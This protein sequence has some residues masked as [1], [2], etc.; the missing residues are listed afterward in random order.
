LGLKTQAA[1]MHAM[2]DRPSDPSSATTAAA[3]AAAAVDGSNNGADGDTAGAAAAG[4]GEGEGGGVLHLTVMERK[5]LRHRATVV[6]RAADALALRLQAV[7]DEIKSA[8]LDISQVRL[9]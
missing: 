7:Q 5:A 6:Q 9:V 4:V 8:T 2:A 3:A 1:D